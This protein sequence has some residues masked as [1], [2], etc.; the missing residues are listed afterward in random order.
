[1]DQQDAFTQNN[2]QENVA[3]PNSDLN[4]TVTPQG[5]SNERC[6][7]IPSVSENLQKYN[8]RQIKQ[9][10][11]ARTTYRTLGSLT[12]KNFKHILRQNLIKNCPVTLRDVEIAEDIYGPDIAALKGHNT[13]KQPPV[14]TDDQVNIPDKLVTSWN[15]LTLYIDNMYVLGQVFLTAMDTTIRY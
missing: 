3:I 6:H 7:A 4:T 1:M 9:A 12:I 10:E 5:A 11:Q 2:Q 13:Q 15:D 8:Y 14:V